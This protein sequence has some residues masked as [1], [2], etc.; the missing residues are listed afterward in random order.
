MPDSP[1]GV[2][3]VAA[4]LRCATYCTAPGVI[5][6]IVVDQPG[7]GYS[8][9]PNV[10][11]RDGT[12]YDPSPNPGTGATATAT[13]LVQTVV[14]DTFG[15]GYTSAPTV[16]ITDTAPGTGT[17]AV[18]TA[19]TDYGTVTAINCYQRGHRISHR[20]RHQEVR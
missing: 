6:A 17:G 20:G 4:M 2:K 15:A 1:D 7:S 19:T 8:F 12:L 14:L 9:A 16:T 13:L 5:T 10:V 11:I 3:A 18:A